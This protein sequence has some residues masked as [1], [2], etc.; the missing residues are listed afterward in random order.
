MAKGEKLSTVNMHWAFRGSHFVYGDKCK[1]AALQAHHVNL[2]PAE[3]SLPALLS[4]THLSE[5]YAKASIAKLGILK[6]I[7]YN[8]NKRNTFHWLYNEFFIGF[9]MTMKFYLLTFLTAR[10]ILHNHKTPT[11][12]HQHAKHPFA[13]NHLNE[14][15]GFSTS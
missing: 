12:M 2:E 14:C 15:S 5:H 7:N 13:D 1:L 4:F 11:M 6:N 3:I 8:T 9:T 10:M